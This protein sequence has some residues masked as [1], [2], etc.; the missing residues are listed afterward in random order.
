MAIFEVNVSVPHKI[1]AYKQA[2]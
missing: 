1:Y 2:Q